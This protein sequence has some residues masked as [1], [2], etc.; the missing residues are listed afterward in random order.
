MKTELDF[1]D[2]ICFDCA[3]LLRAKIFE[4]HAPTIHEDICP[5]CDKKTGILAVSDFDWSN[6]FKNRVVSEI[7]WD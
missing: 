7:N 3:R 1:N 4:N 5:Y 6:K 2:Y